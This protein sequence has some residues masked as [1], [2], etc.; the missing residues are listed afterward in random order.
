MRFFLLDFLGMGW[1]HVNYREY[2]GNGNVAV[3]RTGCRSG[4]QSEN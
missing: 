2:L 1:N 4:S 3:E